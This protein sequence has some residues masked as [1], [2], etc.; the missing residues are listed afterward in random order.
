MDAVTNAVLAV[1][2]ARLFLEQDNYD[3]RCEP[4]FEKAS[5]L[6][7]LPG[8]ALLACMQLYCGVQGPAGG[9][10]VAGLRRPRTRF[11]AQPPPRLCAASRV[12]MAFVDP[13]LARR[14]TRTGS[15]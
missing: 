14:W 2:N 7:R 15:K 3:I 9:G 4:E 11:S 13:D 12:I 8:P 1:G 5:Q 10:E 6:R